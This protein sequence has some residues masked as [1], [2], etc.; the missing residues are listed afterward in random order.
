MPPGRSARSAPI[1]SAPLTARQHGA[2]GAGLALVERGGPAAPL[3]AGPRIRLSFETEAGGGIAHVRIERRGA[4]GSTWQA[5]LRSALR[6]P[7]A[8]V[9][10]KANTAALSSLQRGQVV[11]DLRSLP[12][13]TGDA[14]VVAEADRLLYRLAGLYERYPWLQEAVGVSLVPA[15]SIPKTPKRH[16]RR[17]RPAGI[18]P[19]GARPQRSQKP[20]PCVASMSCNMR[21]AIAV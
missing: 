8:M 4:S 13:P 1:K 2:S 3:P 5:G 10:N 12:V 21:S 20:S 17:R 19:P 11:V 15:T 16:R 18:S 14:A 9:L 7:P 6:M